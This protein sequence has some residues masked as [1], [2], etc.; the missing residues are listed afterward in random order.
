MFCV[1]CGTP[2]PDDA[3]FCLKCGCDL[4]NLGQSPGTCNLATHD[5]REGEYIT[6][7][8]Y[9]Q[10]NKSV[11]E[12]IEWL[13]LENDGK[14]ALLISRYG[15]DRYCWSNYECSWPGSTLRAWLNKDFLKKAFSNDE[16]GMIRFSELRNDDGPEESCK[17]SISR[18]RVFCLSISETKQFFRNVNEIQCLP[19][20]Y[21]TRKGVMEGVNGCCKWWLRSPGF[22]SD[23]GE[24]YAYKRPKA[25]G[26]GPHDPYLYEISSCVRPALRIILKS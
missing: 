24:P 15:L 20:V 18:D 22:V 5:I 19:T 4:R 14:E 25:G 7:G 12:P 2:L 3:N 1:N 21:A 16:L 6:F 10:N 23:E 17:G 26:G 9:P 11:K 13:V 8:R